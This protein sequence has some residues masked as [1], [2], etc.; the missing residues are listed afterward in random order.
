MN[1]YRGFQSLKPAESIDYGVLVY[2]GDFPVSQAAALGRAQHANQLLAAGK[3]DQALPLAREA[4]AIDPG[5]IIS[6]T[7]LG[8]IASTLGQKDE[9][10]Q[11][12]QAA[13]ASARRLEPD[14]QASYV[15]DLEKKL[16]KL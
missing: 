4:V 9:A 10:R 2:R 6:Q 5:E 1:P 15:P 7:T 12:W 14:A 3:P 11:A 13:I 16:R 8:D